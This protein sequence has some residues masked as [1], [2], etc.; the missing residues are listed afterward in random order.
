M[1]LARLLRSLTFRLALVYLALFSASVAVLLAIT[2]WT[3][4]ARPLE[5][6]R[7][8]VA[9]EA[10]ALA[11]TYILDGPA[12]LTAQLRQRAATISERKAF[13]AFIAADGSTTANLPSWPERS[14]DGW[15]RFEADLYVDGDE[16]DHEALVYEQRFRDG[17]R[18]FV[19]RDIEDIDERGELI[20]QLTLWGA[21]AVVI[22]GLAGGLL[23]SVAVGRRIEAVTATARQVIAGDL[24]G[25]VPTR[26]SGDDFDRLGDTLNDMLARIEALVE[27]VSR[28]SDSIAH[29]LRTPLARLQADLEE[30]GDNRDPVERRR[31]VDA[32]T[33]EAARLQ[34]TFDALLRIARLESGRHAITR[35]PV[36]LARLLD[37]A[38]DF[39]APE[40]E[41]RGMALDVRCENGIAVEGDAN[42]LFQAVTNL[43]DNALKHAPA[44]GRIAVAGRREAGATVVEVAD[45]GPGIPE[46]HRAKV[47][48]RFYRVPGSEARDGIGLGLTLVAAIARAHGAALEMAD[49][50]PGL[51]IRLRFPAP[52]ALA[53]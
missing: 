15:R 52:E 27:A 28:V 26:G 16:E 40:A 45:D 30:L 2:W 44:G 9:R 46:A 36:E 22:L 21:V 41:A 4:V 34:A 18:L 8:A 32:A 1:T 23:M 53:R 25:R 47:T 20:E 10:D 33:A 37:D 13:H 29:E 7:T 42:L 17:A 5:D 11:D 50:R 43:L 24:S 49:N 48:E 14:G 3:S 31:L 19:G 51:A 39:Y 6:V 35:Q 12:A 38:G